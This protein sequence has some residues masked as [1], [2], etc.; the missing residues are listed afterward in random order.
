[1]SDPFAPV[2]WRGGSERKAAPALIAAPEVQGDLQYA[3]RR[4]AALG[5]TPDELRAVHDAW[6]LLSDDWGP[7][8]QAAFA[9]LPD[10]DLLAELERVRAEFAL[11]TTTEQEAADERDRKAYD[12][13]LE[14]ALGRVGG[15]VPRIL[16]WVAA[17]PVRARAVLELE[18]HP[19]GQGRKTLVAALGDILGAGG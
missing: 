2:G 14:D 19:Q 15:T 9:R 6:G 3:L 12:A 5:A 13:A 7:D 16:E 17:D 1:M 8:E 18:A 11:G 10:A 4:L